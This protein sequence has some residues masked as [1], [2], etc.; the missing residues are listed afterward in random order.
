MKELLLL[1]EMEESLLL[2]EMEETNG[3]KFWGKTRGEHPCDETGH[4]LTWERQYI[5]WIGVSID[6]NYVAC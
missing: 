3:G 4:K 2:N 1:N 6:Y 5:F